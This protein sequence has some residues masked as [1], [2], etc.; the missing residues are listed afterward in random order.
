MIEENSIGAGKFASHGVTPSQ[1][2]RLLHS[3]G[4]S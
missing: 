2:A 1:F 3:R 4:L